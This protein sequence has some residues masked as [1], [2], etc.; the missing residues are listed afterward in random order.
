M[1]SLTD[2]RFVDLIKILPVREHTVV[3]PP[4]KLFLLRGCK[5]EKGLP[6]S[7]KEIFAEKETIEKL[8]KTLLWGYPRGIQKWLPA[9]FGDNKSLN[10]LGGKLSS[11]DRTQ[12][13]ATEDISSETLF[14]LTKGDNK[15]TNLGPVTLS[16]MA[17]FFRV[18]VEG[19]E[20]LILDNRII[21]AAEKWEDLCKIGLS[22]GSFEPQ[23][24]SEYLKKMCET[25]RYIGCTPDQLEF[26]LFAFGGSFG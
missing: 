10:I 17:Y 11:W 24:Y 25:A 19:S 3:V 8:K 1:K 26:F 15:I 14:G 7:R 13:P 4:K 2:S 6:I 16:K 20:A 21:K 5:Q 9:L 23:Q 12:N 18:I 22:G